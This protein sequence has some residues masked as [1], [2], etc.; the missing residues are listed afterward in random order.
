MKKI[1]LILSIL[2]IP[3]QTFAFEDY[4]ILS[5]LKVDS[6]YA[7]DDN[8]ASVLPF[9]TI[10][11][12]KN[13]LIVRAKSVGK[14]VII[15]ETDSNNIT[16]NVEISEDKTTLSEFDGITAFPIDFINEPAKPV[17]RGK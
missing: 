10:E 7:K 17:L 6:A 2:L 8:I 15:L 13:M 14:T 9:F 12:N 16:L 4:I 5:D 3:L 11:N 1:I